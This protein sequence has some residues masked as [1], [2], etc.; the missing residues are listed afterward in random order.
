MNAL[1]NAL[2]DFLRVVT[3]MGWHPHDRSYHDLLFLVSRRIERDYL[4]LFPTR[5]NVRFAKAFDATMG[6]RSI[7]NRDTLNGIRVRSGGETFL[8]DTVTRYDPHD[9]RS[10]DA[11]VDDL[12]S[13][14]VVIKR[15]RDFKRYVEGLRLM[16]RLGG[17]RMS[18][19]EPHAL[20]HW[21]NVSDVMGE[22]LYEHV[23]R[24]LRFYDMTIGTVTFSYAMDALPIRI[25]HFVPLDDRVVSLLT[26]GNVK[27]L[28]TLERELRQTLIR[29]F[30]RLPLS[31]ITRP[32]SEVVSYRLVPSVFKTAFPVT[33]RWHPGHARI[34]YRYRGSIRYIR[35][36]RNDHDDNH[37]QVDIVAKVD[38]LTLYD[39]IV[40]HLPTVPLV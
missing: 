26:D 40:N 1:R 34:E 11:I 24:A 6:G 5:D 9:L 20:E 4:V 16:G 28:R 12:M 18:I 37:V 23:T 36:E 19:S 35:I 14:C 38:F 22:G 7:L 31:P 15:G 33:G 8:Y 30:D 17:E 13:V 3:V 21:F 29:R 2:G 25:R 39:F 27:G 32:K 10:L